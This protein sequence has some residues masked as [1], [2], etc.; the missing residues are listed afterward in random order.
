MEVEASWM[1]FQCAKSSNRTGLLFRLRYQFFVPYFKNPI[2]IEGLPVLHQPLGLGTKMREV[3]EITGV[4][5]SIGKHT[6]VN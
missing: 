6:A 2:G 4:T 5:M 1:P 3:F